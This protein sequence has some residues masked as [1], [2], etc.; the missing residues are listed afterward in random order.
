M[1]SVLLCTKC[2]KFHTPST[3]PFTASACIPWLGWDSRCC[4]LSYLTNVPLQVLGLPTVLLTVYYILPCTSLLSC[5]C[6]YQ[7]CCRPSPREKSLYSRI[8]AD[9]FIR[10]CP[11]T[12][13]SLKISRLR[14]LQIVRNVGLCDVHKFCYHLPP[15]H[16]ITVKNVF[17]TDVDQI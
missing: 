16:E 4:G 9:E 6:H 7:K 3:P 13:K 14:I 8:L 12:T 17:F 5:H 15:Q 10:P 2:A 11:W 1:Q